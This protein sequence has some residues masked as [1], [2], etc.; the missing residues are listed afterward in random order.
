MSPADRLR[1]QARQNDIP[2]YKQAR[3]NYEEF[4][5]MKYNI[6]T[7]HTNATQTQTSTRLRRGQ[8]PSLCRRKDTPTPTQVTQ[9]AAV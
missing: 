1:K 2:P 8:L 5:L 6:L 7:G 3:K 4:D 9:H